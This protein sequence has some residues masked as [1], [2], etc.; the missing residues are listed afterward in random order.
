MCFFPFVR[1]DKKVYPYTPSAPPQKRI[2]F[3]RRNTLV[4]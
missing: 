2:T 1:K 3:I 4:T